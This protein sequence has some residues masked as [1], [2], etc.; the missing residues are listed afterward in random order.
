MLAAP[1]TFNEQ[2]LERAMSLGVQAC[3]TKPLSSERLKG[4]MER[5]LKQYI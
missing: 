5:L 1:S 2:Q 3:L 4:E